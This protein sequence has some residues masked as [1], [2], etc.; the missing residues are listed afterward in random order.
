MCREALKWE[1]K[2]LEHFQKLAY[3]FAQEESD[4][5]FIWYM[6]VVDATARKDCGLIE[7]MSNDDW[8]SN[9]RAFVGQAKAEQISG[10]RDALQ[11]ILSGDEWKYISFENLVM[12]KQVMDGP[13]DLGNLEDYYHV[14]RSYAQMGAV[15]QSTAQAVN[16]IC[17][18]LEME[19]Q[20]KIQAIKHLKAAV[21]ECPDFAEG[22]A[23]FIG[24]YG[25]LEKQRAAKQRK[26]MQQLRNQVVE[27]VK[28]MMAAGQNAEAM[29]I[30]AQLKQMFPEDMEIIALGLEARINTLK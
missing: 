2:D 24:A 13:A 30:V 20:D 4:F 27:Q 22:V 8:E 11:S 28:G 5:W 10:V 21:D 25:D 16:H 14:L 23:K 18:Y 3:I 6:K 19:S 15:L 9:A 1:E 7:Q 12:E 26:E 29:A 17:A